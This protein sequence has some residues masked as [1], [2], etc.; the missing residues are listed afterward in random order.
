MSPLHLIHCDINLT[1]RKTFSVVY[2]PA[3]EPVFTGNKLMDCLVWLHDNEID[4]CEIDN[5]LHRY[6]V[7]I[8]P[9]LQQTRPWTGSDQAV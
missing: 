6:T 7:A 8:D 9:I 3:G 4:T 2:N 5:G 1:R